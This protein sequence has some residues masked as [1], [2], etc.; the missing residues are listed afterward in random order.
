MVRV[1]IFRTS[2]TLP[3]QKTYEVLCKDFQLDMNN[4]QTCSIFEGSVR[5]WNE[6]GQGKSDVAYDLVGIRNTWTVQNF[7]GGRAQ[8]G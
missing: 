4:P 1:T 2:G 6:A 5:D 7:K 3:L 8:H